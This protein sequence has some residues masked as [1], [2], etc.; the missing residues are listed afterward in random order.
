MSQLDC[1][2]ELHGHER[3]AGWKSLAHARDWDG[4]VEQLLLE[5][6][7]PAYLKSINRNFKQAA[8]ARV[9]AISSDAVSAF[10]AAARE[11]AA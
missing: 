10:D 11:L 2:I 8:G 3:I 4:M 5:H 7:D 9:L 6:Y 1:L